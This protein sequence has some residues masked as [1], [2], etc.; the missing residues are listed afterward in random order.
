MGLS[1]QRALSVVECIF[2]SDELPNFAYKTTLQQEL[3][4]NGWSKVELK[5][6]SKLSHRVEF[7]FRLRDINAFE[8][9][10]ADIK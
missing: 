2:N 9:S 8:T 10:I 5:G 6:A 3:S 7:K 1:L 4:A